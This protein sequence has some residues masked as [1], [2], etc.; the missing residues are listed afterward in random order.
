MITEEEAF[1]AGI[2]V[3]TMM[4]G[5][6]FSMLFIQTLT[7]QGAVV[8]ALGLMT[9]ALTLQMRAGPT[10]AEAYPPFE[11]RILVPTAPIEPQSELGETQPPPEP[12]RAEAKTEHP[13]SEPQEAPLR[14]TEPSEVAESDEPPKP[15][16]Q[17]QPQSQSEPNQH[18][19]T[20]PPQEGTPVEEKKETPK[21][22]KKPEEEPIVIV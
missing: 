22:E 17:P 18:S 4:L 7:G 10:E 9:M 21:T 11:S 6:G 20:Q 5:G 15:V 2:A 3:A 8:L 1:W 12:S 19:T 14:S 13:P 16:E